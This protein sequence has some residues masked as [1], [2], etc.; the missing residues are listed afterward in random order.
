MIE[1]I[2]NCNYSV[3]RLTV[4]DAL[5]TIET[6]SESPLKVSWL[7]PLESIYKLGQQAYM[8]KSQPVHQQIKHQ[9]NSKH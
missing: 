9:G 5:Q 4:E 7:V 8:E 6:Y 2:P 1:Q 3:P